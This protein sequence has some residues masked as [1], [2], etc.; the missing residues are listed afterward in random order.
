MNNERFLSVPENWTIVDI[1]SRRVL[2]EVGPKE[3]KQTVQ[4]IKPLI[5][6]AT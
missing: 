1:V 3:L 5:D 6:M 2:A 4:F